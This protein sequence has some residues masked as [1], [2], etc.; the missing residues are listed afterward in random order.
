[1]NKPLAIIL[2]VVG[3]VGVGVVS[4]FHE[5]VPHASPEEIKP[6]VV[7]VWI[8]AIMLTLLAIKTLVT[9]PA[10]TASRR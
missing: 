2:A 7:P 10:T 6:F 1:M 3:W 4:N 5:I 9:K 8:L